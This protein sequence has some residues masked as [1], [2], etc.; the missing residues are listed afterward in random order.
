MIDYKAIATDLIT[1]RQRYQLDNAPAIAVGICTAA[2]ANCL[3][4]DLGSRAATVA[5]QIFDSIVDERGDAGRAHIQDG[6][7]QGLARLEQT[8]ETV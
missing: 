1:G 8:K 5:G 7:D 6:P 2:P 3:L 4:P